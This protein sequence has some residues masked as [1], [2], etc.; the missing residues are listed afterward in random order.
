MVGPKYPVSDAP[1][2]S[3]VWSND[4]QERRG[5]PESAAWTPSPTQLGSQGVQ[6]Q[7]TVRRDASC[8]GVCATGN[9]MCTMYMSQWG[10]CGQDEL[11]YQTDS[12]LQNFG[13]GPGEVERMSRMGEVTDCRGC[14]GVSPPQKACPSICG[15]NN[16][17]R[18]FS[19]AGYCGDDVLWLTVDGRQQDFGWGQGTVERL[20]R[21]GQMTDCTGCL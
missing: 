9:T 15:R 1:T 6:T 16:C 8:P 20:T 7:A 12:G 14:E 17:K 5:K 3:A 18:Y 21:Q 13:W 11:W 10:I 19:S 4:T 2:P